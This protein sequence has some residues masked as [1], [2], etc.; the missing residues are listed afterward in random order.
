LFSAPLASVGVDH[1]FSDHLFAQTNADFYP[2][3]LPRNAISNIDAAMMIMLGGDKFSVGE[4][5]QT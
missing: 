5:V 4:K 3:H 1:L 2:V